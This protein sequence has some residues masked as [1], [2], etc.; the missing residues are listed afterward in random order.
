MNSNKANLRFSYLLFYSVIVILIYRIIN[1]TQGIKY[2][3][4]FNPFG[5]KKCTIFNDAYKF[6]QN[7]YT[8]MLLER[9]Q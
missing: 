7:E 6:L 9:M 2:S 8:G 4:V 3:Q 1:I 5:K